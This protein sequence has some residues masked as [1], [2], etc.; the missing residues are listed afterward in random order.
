MVPINHHS[1][2]M[3]CFCVWK[4]TQQL[5]T[6]YGPAPAVSA[7]RTTL[8]SPPAAA[9]ALHT[10]NH[11]AIRPGHHQYI[12]HQNG[13]LKQIKTFNTFAG[14]AEIDDV[15][16]ERDAFF[17]QRRPHPLRI[18]APV[19]CMF[20]SVHQS[21]ASKHHHSISASRNEIKQMLSFSC[22]MT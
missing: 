20:I 6:I 8:A 2:E 3:M 10:A 17:Q 15:Q 21:V 12:N 5:I 14:M 7:S 1:S 22:E 13:V 4:M 16:A 18:G 11:Q 9:A 19:R